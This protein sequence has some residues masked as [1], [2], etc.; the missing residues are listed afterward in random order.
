MRAEPL[1]CGSGS[2]GGSGAVGRRVWLQVPSR[3]AELSVLPDHSGLWAEPTG[4]DEPGRGSRGL[5]RLCCRPQRPAPVT[6][7]TS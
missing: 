7:K 6:T 5:T 3:G 2:W 1:T 4:V